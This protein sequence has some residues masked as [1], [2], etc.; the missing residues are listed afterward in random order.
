MK[1]KA[2]LKDDISGLGDLFLDIIE[3]RKDSGYICPV[4]GDKN[5]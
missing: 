4:C 5:A 3:I 2:L 1:K